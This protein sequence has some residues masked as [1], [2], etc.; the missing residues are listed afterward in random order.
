[1]CF[2]VLQCVAFEVLWHHCSALQSVAV[3]HSV[4]LS[5]CSVTATVC[6]SILQFAVCCS[7]LQ[8]VAVCCSRSALSLR[9]CVAVCCCVQCVAVCSVL[10]CS[11]TAVSLPGVHLALERSRARERCTQGNVSCISCALC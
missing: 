6:C 2:S 10:C 11:R 4:L 8:R 5:K 3:C 1:V 7:V 9:Q